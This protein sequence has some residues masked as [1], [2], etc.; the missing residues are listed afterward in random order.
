M[1]GLRS[2][3]LRP[4]AAAIVALAFVAPLAF[5]FT[6]PCAG[7]GWRRRRARS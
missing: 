4:L 2:V 7:L 1:K 3:N 5:F 6:G